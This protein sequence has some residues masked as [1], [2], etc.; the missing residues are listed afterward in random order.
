MTTGTEELLWELIFVIACLALGWL[1]LKSITDFLR[2]IKMK[3]KDSSVRQYG[4]Q[5]E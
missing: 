4:G 3:K 5:E 1:T 2:E